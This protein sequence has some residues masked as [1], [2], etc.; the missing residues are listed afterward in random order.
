MPDVQ[1]TKS[2]PGPTAY[3]DYNATNA[4]TKPKCTGK[5]SSSFKFLS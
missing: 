3:T 1:T 2:D 4:G 5:Y